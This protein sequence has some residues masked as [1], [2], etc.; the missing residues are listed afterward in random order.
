M[1]LL[2]AGK[3][4]VAVVRALPETPGFIARRLI[5]E[6][7]AAALNSGHPLATVTQIELRELAPYPL[8][9]YRGRSSHSVADLLIELCKQAGF[10]PEIQTERSEERRVGKECVSTG[11]SQWTP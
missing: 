5:D 8:I 1:E 6:P 3:I 4:D 9:V 10:I 7:I 2:A 11:R